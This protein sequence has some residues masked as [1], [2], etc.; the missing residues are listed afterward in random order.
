MKRSLSPE[1]PSSS[2]AA[3]CPDT[4]LGLSMAERALALPRTVSSAAPTPMM[5]ATAKI[6]PTS[7]VKATRALIKTN[8][9]ATAVIHTAYD[10]GLDKL[11]PDGILGTVAMD[12]GSLGIPARVPYCGVKSALS[13]RDLFGVLHAPRPDEVLAMMADDNRALFDSSMIG[14]YDTDRWDGAVKLAWVQEEELW[15]RMWDESRPN[16]MPRA[17]LRPWFYTL[18]VIGPTL[19]EL[20]V[21]VEKH[22][23]V[24]RRRALLPHDAR[25]LAVRRA[26]RR[27]LR[28]V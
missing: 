27:H 5:T 10:E 19:Q 21:V 14:F 20:Q 16:V 2:R 15:A 4:P 17:D 13:E 6:P 22:A 26:R 18:N 24:A 28:D 12:I 3:S 9:F 23:E 7:M 8:K 25:H 1:P 11:Q